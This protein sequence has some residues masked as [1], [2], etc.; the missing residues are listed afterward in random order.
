MGTK[1]LKS[2]DKISINDLEDKQY[3]KELIQSRNINIGF[4]EHFKMAMKEPILVCISRN[5]KRKENINLDSIYDA[6]L[7]DSNI[8]LKEDEVLSL[9][10]N[11]EYKDAHKDVRYPFKTDDLP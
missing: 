3:L 6:L 10:R 7:I 1:V 5:D 8:V 2:R 11:N 9:I 4:H